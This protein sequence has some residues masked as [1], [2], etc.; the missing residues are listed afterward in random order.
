MMM[1]LMINDVGC[2]CGAGDGG[3]GCGGSSGGG[4]DDDDDQIIEILK[5]IYFFM[6]NFHLI[7]N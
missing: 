2:D 3:C 7:S 5:K 6:K 1:V 4:D